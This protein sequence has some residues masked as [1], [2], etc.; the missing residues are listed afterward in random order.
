MYAHDRTMIA[1]LGFA[2]PDRQNTKHDLACRYLAEEKQRAAVIRAVNP[3]LFVASE[4]ERVYAATQ[5]A[6]SVSCP[7]CK[8][9]QRQ[10][11]FEEGKNIH[12][13]HI[14]TSIVDW[15]AERIAPLKKL[16]FYLSHSAACEVPIS[17]GEGQYKTTIG[18]VDT[19][20]DVIR[21]LGEPNAATS[22]PLDGWCIGVEVKIK[23]TSWAEV[24]RQIKLYKEYLDCDTWVLAAAYPMPEG[25]VK[26]LKDNQVGV[27]SLGKKFEAWATRQPK[28]TPTTTP[29]V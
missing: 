21:D 4:D 12:D 7:K 24:L 10:R 11:C 9:K 29:E 16:K 6:A 20:I 18:F 8:S 25:D 15:H 3:A 28:I 23:R 2:D 19:L 13:G 14:F 1:R 5:L 17:K 22:F 26:A 27:I